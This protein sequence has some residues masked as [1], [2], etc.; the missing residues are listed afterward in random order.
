MKK[1]LY[2]GII[3]ILLILIVWILLREGPDRRRVNLDNH[4][5]KI[6]LLLPHNIDDKSWN[7]VGFEAMQK[8]SKEE[9]IQMYWHQNVD[10]VSVDSIVA[11]YAEEQA[12]LVVG[13]GG[14]FDLAFEKTALNY[15]HI[16]F[17][18]VGRH[19][20][21]GRNFGSISSG[22]GF[23]YLAGVLAAM[24]SKSGHIAAIMGKEL[25]H[26]KAET[27]AFEAGAKSIR[28]D[29]KVSVRFT[30][31]WEEQTLAMKLANE[32]LDANA[33]VLLVNLDKVSPV[34]HRMAQQRSVYSISVTTDERD[35]YPGSV[36]GAVTT[37]T[38][39]KYSAAVKLFLKGHWEGKMYRFGLTEGATTVELQEDVLSP[40]QKVVYDNVYASLIRKQIKIPELSE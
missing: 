31:S 23:F 28:S 9:N 30:G 25:E 2:I 14:E 26:I 32:L 40:E 37:N 15:P 3:S 36:I 18:L 13:H 22:N 33:D 7:Q 16:K 5:F 6:L 38:Y 20:G 35:N 19:H 39:K 1:I 11:Q 4:P 27:I 8:V 29:I 24:K 10:P 12:L 34:V 21:N 17:A